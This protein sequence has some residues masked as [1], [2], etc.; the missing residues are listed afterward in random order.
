MNKSI[1]FYST[2]KRYEILR[3]IA[4]AEDLNSL[5]ELLGEEIEK[6]SVV[7]GYLINL[8][9]QSG[10]E[11]ISMKIRFPAGY[12]YLE[13]TYHGYKT[14]VNGD[15]ANPNVRA[16]QSRR[17][18]R[19]HANEGLESDKQILTR[20]NVDESSHLPMTDSE[21][22]DTPPL[23]ILTLMR[24]NA[25]IDQLAFDALNELISIFYAPLRTALNTSFLKEFQQRFQA[26]ADE[27]ARAL[28]FI[29][30]LNNLTES[31]KVFDMFAVELFRRIPFECIGFFLHE[32]G[33]LKSKMVACSAPQFDS[34]KDEWS[35]YLADK[36]Y[37]LNS[38]DGGVAHAFLKNA[39]MM[40]QDVQQVLHMPMSEKDLQTL[41]ILK[42]PRTLLVLPI[43]YQKQPIGSIA[44]FSLTKIIDVSKADLRMLENLSSFL[45]TAIINSNNF[46]LTKEQNAQLQRLASHDAL[47]GLPNRALLMDRL[48]QGLARWERHKQKATIAFVDLDHFKNINDSLGHT[49]GDKTLVAVAE[50]L[51]GAIRESDTVARFGGDEFVLI[52]EDQ[53]GIDSHMRVLERI[54]A[55]LCEPIPDLPLEIAITSSIGYS[56]YPEDGTNA[57]TLL[58]AADA[59]MYLA[60][61]L[62]RSNIQP[63]TADMRMQ[64]LE[65][66]T[67]ETKLRYAVENNQLI[68]HYQPKVDLRT[69]HVVGMEALVR[70]NHP[71]LGMVLPGVFIPIAEES[72][73]IVP[74]GDWIL[75]TACEQALA[76]KQA[77][78]PIPVAVNLSAKQFQQP[79]IS[80]RVRFALESIGLDAQYLELELTESMSMV[81][82][83]KSIAIMQTFKELG[84]TLTI[85]DFGTGYSNLSYLKRFPVDKLKLDQSFVRDMTQSAEALAISQAVLAVAHNLGLK[86]VAEGVETESQL[87]L[88]A[89]NH[90]DEVQGF[91]FSKPLSAEQCTA[92]FLEN[93]RL[94]TGEIPQI[95]N[96]R[97]I[98][99]VDDGVRNPDVLGME[100]AQSG[101]RILSAE[102]PSVALEMLATNADIAIVL[103]DHAMIDMNG[104]DFLNNVK[105]MYPAIVRAMLSSHP[106]GDFLMN[107]INRNLVF[108]FIIRHAEVE[109]IKSAI[110]ECYS[111][112]ERL[113]AIHLHALSPKLSLRSK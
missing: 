82:P 113:A 40:F 43:R 110:A 19:V 28:E 25:L 100:L 21:N 39:S 69:G 33:G 9:G 1:Q 89:R 20:W 76:W 78:T 64:A 37:G 90:C 68:L 15:S 10:D 22:Q 92:F 80:S 105:H 31:D 101:Y 36:L 87:N 60:K 44:F 93:R 63:Y 58:N 54:S 55:A 61:Q 7:D 4:K 8:C 98:L 51:R 23:G 94:S 75:R 99:I 42:T 86:V 73:L 67:M 32:N 109:S 26:A 97:T 74:M 91:Y 53:N 96:N 77:G 88:L 38:M 56:C 108:R 3:S 65:R 70:W 18:V 83:E 72:G 6:L 2:E 30:E 24:K 46:A 52:L 79:D 95:G 66:L 35:A 47:T 81:N 85:D 71:E 111:E 57:D 11:I 29:I 107:A 50:K 106:D 45:G 103:A 62:G 12:R 17:I 48:R 59:A 102:S 5:L 34:I 13:K 84:I 41:R 27:Q 16:F 104:L 112:Y 14:P 49:A